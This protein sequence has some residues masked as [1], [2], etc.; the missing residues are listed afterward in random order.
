M[1]DTQACRDVLKIAV[2]TE[3]NIC[4][5]KTRGSFDGN[6]IFAEPVSF[7]LRFR[8]V[9]NVYYTTAGRGNA[10]LKIT[11]FRSEDGQRHGFFE[12]HLYTRWR[13][14]IKKKKGKR[15]F[16]R[17]QKTQRTRLRLP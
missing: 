7:D 17:E 9:L 10:N 5:R 1:P 8:R 14:V 4:L 3:T 11:N 15:T 13:S 2:N 16:H 12:N 6:K